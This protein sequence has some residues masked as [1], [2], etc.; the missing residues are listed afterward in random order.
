MIHHFTAKDAQVT[1][2]LKKGCPRFGP[3]GSS[4]RPSVRPP[5]RFPPSRL[6]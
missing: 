2:A 5:A 3:R 1:K 6:L 4:V